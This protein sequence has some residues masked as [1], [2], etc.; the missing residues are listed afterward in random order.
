FPERLLPGTGNRRARAVP[1]TGQAAHGP[2]AHARAATPRPGLEQRRPARQAERHR[3]EPGRRGSAC[4]SAD[5]NARKGRRKPRGNQRRATRSA[6]PALR[7]V[8]NYY[9]YYRVDPAKLADLRVAIE[10]VFRSVERETGVRGRWM[11]RRDD[12]TTYMEVYEGVQ[13]G[14]AFDA[15]LE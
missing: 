11:H 1:R 10:E 9:V 5:R 8:T 4:G 7:G 12:P 3:R 14:A 2:R 13:D 6:P 15:L